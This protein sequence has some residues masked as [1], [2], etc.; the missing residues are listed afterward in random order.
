MNFDEID[1]IY[2]IKPASTAAEYVALIGITNNK[3]GI[4]L[5]SGDDVPAELLVDTSFFNWLLNERKAIKL[6]DTGG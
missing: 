6:K 5:H 1:D 3:L 2:E 4:R